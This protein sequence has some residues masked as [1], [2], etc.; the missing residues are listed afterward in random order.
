MLVPAAVLVLVVLGAIAVDSAIVF[1]AQRNLANATAAAANDIAGRGVGAPG[2]SGT[3][4]VALSPARADAYMQ[5][6]FDGAPLP[7]G[8]EWRT[9]DATVS[10][11][12]VE[13]TASA[14]VRHFFALAFGW[15]ERTT[16]VRA[17]SRAGA[18]TA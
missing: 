5:A 14:G 4:A 15:A 7:A 2:L 12:T 9:W 11:S 3:G 17:T 18:A 10:G 1:L 13:V 16:V 8:M 6:V